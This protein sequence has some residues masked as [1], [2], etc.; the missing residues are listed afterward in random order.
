MAFVRGLNRSAGTKK[1]AGPTR[2]SGRRL[3]ARLGAGSE[4]QS[5]LETAF[6][7]PILMTLL[8]SL[9]YVSWSFNN[10]IML[11]QAVGAGAS[12]LQ[13]TAQNTETQVPDPCLLTTEVILAKEPNLAPASLNLKYNLN[14]AI[15]SVNGAA[16]GAQCAGGSSNFALGGTVQISATYP[17]SMA[18]LSGL[19]NLITS[20]S[21]FSGTCVIQE[22]QTE[23]IY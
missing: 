7:L 10:K 5:T 3:R 13:A 17:C 15:Y 19:A 22:Q 11:T 1:A 4:G 18:P 21:V 2:L 14:G 12:Y 20:G 23:L 6:M 16:S 8:M 9:F